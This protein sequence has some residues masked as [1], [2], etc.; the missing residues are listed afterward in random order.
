M[1]CQLFARK[2]KLSSLMLVPILV[3]APFLQWGFH[4]IREI[5]AQS[6]NRHKWILITTNY[7]SKW[8][9]AIPIKNA[10]DDFFIKFL[11]ENILSRFGF[12]QQIVTDNAPTFR[13]V[14]MI[15]FFQ[16]YS[17]ILHHS[18]PYY[19]QGNGLADSSNNILVKFIKNTLEYHKKS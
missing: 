6:R 9:E 14:K 18:T 7:F 12:T 17:I 11:E 5:H 13:S 10:I 15:E 16:K 1:P 4:F 19:P 8:V 2:Q 3:H